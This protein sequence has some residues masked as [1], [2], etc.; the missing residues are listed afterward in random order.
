[1]SFK[2]SIG[3]S[4]KQPTYLHIYLLYNL[5]L[6]AECIKKIDQIFDLLFLNEK[7]SNFPIDYMKCKFLNRSEI[8]TTTLSLILSVLLDSLEKLLSLFN[9]T[10]DSNDFEFKYEITLLTCKI[11]THLN[12]VI[13]YKIIQIFN[14]TNRTY[15]SLKI[16]SKLNP[17]LLIEILIDCDKT[18]VIM[19]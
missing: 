2:L 8:S 4:I 6:K 17:R 18:M 9:A 5:N 12:K 10:F 11:W 19:K 3:N 15:F 14:I 7:I 16:L 13:F 1:M